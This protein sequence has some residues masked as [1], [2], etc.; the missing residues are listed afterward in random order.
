MGYL[1]FVPLSVMTAANVVSLPV[2]AVVGTAIN[3]GKGL[4]FRNKPFIL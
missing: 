2:P 4:Y 3:S 1:C